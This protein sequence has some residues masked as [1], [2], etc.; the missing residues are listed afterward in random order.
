MMRKAEVKKFVRTHLPELHRDHGFEFL[1]GT[2]LGR[3]SEYVL[4]GICF[5]RHSVDGFA[6]TPYVMPLIYPCRF[7]FLS[8]GGRV[9]GSPYSNGRVSSFY[10]LA[11]D[12]LSESVELLRSA[13]SEVCLPFLAESTTIAAIADPAYQDRWKRFWGSRQGSPH[14]KAY[15]AA[16]AERMEDFRWY[17]SKYCTDLRESDPD[18]V[19]LEVTNLLRVESA[20]DDPARLRSLFN[21]F[22][23]QSIEALNLGRLGAQPPPLLN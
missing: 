14:L 2:N 10:S 6:L 15:V 21:E 12:R 3:V 16:F 4:Q 7:L 23:R 17:R 5:N 1:D 8:L 20:L 18:W 22:A 13:I 11:P 19:K 9:G